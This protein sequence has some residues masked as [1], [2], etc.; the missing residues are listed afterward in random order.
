MSEKIKLVPLVEIPSNKPIG[1]SANQVDLVILKVD[2]KIF[3]Y[4]GNCPHQFAPL[5]DGKIQN[6][7]LVCQMHGWRFDCLTGQKSTDSSICLR[8]YQTFEEDGFLMIEEDELTSSEYSHLAEPSFRSINDL[9]GPSGLPVVGNVLQI[10]LPQFHKQLASWSEQFGSVYKL[11]LGPEVA[12]VI[13]KPDIIQYV[14]KHRPHDFRRLSKMDNVMKEIGVDGVFNAEGDNWKRQ[15][16]LAAKGL[17]VSHLIH[18]FPTMVQVCER[19]F[20]RWNQSLNSPFQIQKDLMRFTV[21]VTTNLT[22]GYDINT[23]EKEGNVIQDHLEKVLLPLWRRINA[24]FPYWRIFKPP[25]ERAMEQSF[26]SIMQAIDQFIQ[27]A[28]KRMKEKPDLHNKPTNFLEALLTKTDEDEAFSDDEIAGNAFTMLLAGEDTTA[29]TL[30]WMI[31]YLCIYPA[32][33]E[34]IYA[35]VKEVL[36]E[37]PLLTVY[38]TSK[39]LKYIEAFTFETMRM[40]PVAPVLFLEALKNTRLEDLNVPKG[41]SLFLQT[42]FATQKDENFSRAHEFNPKR[43]LDKMENHNEDSFVPFGAGPRFCPGRSLALLEIKVVIA[44]LCKNFKVSL[45]TRSDEIQELLHFT[46]MPSAFEVKLT[47]R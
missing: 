14:L 40:K 11:K 44:M 19:L 16:K 29:N 15:R 17:N 38:E 3:T 20:N 26:A 12:V 1:V 42:Q 4:Q 34:R 6:G 46:L 47:R 35:E 21:D 31:Y 8:S 2:D 10:K 27:E 37:N 36:K 41:T 22:F 28:K 13:T 24:P 43:W 25:S 39:Q 33:Q 45:S 18:F 32:V 23:I 30:T 5:E 7:Q 9:P